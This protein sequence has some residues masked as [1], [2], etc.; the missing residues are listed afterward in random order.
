MGKPSK[1]VTFSFGDGNIPN[2]ENTPSIDE[3][4]IRIKEN[5]VYFNH[6]RKVNTKPHTAPKTAQP[7]V[8]NIPPTVMSEFKKACR[9]NDINVDQKI[10]RMMEQFIQHT[11]RLVNN[12]IFHK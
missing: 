2:D 11:N 1:K 6:E 4:L 5:P 12:E 9:I 3:I 10:I 7:T 8:I